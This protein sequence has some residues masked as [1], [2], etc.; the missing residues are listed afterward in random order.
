MTPPIPKAGDPIRVD[1]LLYAL[2]F[3]S[4]IPNEA[5]DGFLTARE[6]VRPPG[7]SEADEAALKANF[8]YKK[9]SAFLE[10]DLVWTA[11]EQGLADL[12]EQAET[13]A[14]S[15]PH[16]RVWCEEAVTVQ[17][18]VLA[19]AGSCWTLPGRHLLKPPVRYN[20]NRNAAGAVI[21]YESFYPQ[22]RK[23][24]AALA[25]AILDSA[26]CPVVPLVPQEG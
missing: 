21:G 10:A 11:P 14:R 5:R 9:S 1:G 16:T 18:A 19:E 4:R 13:L 2:G 25:Q 20:P 15:R 26:P 24:A 22:D 17:E 3:T 8:H 7:A 23:Q 12:R 6:C